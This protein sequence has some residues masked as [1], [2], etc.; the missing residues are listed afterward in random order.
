MLLYL[1]VS[2]LKTSIILYKH[3]FKAGLM[4]A[5]PEVALGEVKV[6]QYGCLAG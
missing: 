4:T 3:P 2:V 1:S 5:L 6:K